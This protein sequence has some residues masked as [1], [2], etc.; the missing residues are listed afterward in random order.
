MHFLAGLVGFFFQSP[1]SEPLLTFRYFDL[2]CALL[3]F[4]YRY[5][6][7]RNK[8]NMNTR[9]PMITEDNIMNGT[10]MSQPSQSPS[11]NFPRLMTTLHEI[12]YDNVTRSKG[13]MK[14][15][16]IFHSS[17]SLMTVIPLL[18][19]ILSRRKL[20]TKRS[21]QLFINLLGIHILFNSSVIVSNFI[22]YSVNEVII[23]CCLL[24]AM[25]LGLLLM[26]KPL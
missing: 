6:S 14:I 25:F 20:R 26:L 10:L 18:I 22:P 15:D 23:N 2:D 21:H 1:L 4:S 19:F 17:V 11:M 16:E 12:S 5:Q 9:A 13:T 3:S 8:Y 24:I 7:S